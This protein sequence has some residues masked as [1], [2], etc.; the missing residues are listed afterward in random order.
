M[1]PSSGLSTLVGPPAA[2]RGLY[3]G[4]KMSDIS[5]TSSAQ[6]WRKSVYVIR[7]LRS[8]KEGVFDDRDGA[9][10]GVLLSHLLC[11]PA[12]TL[13]LYQPAQSACC[14]HY[15][16]SCQCNGYTT[17]K[18]RTTLKSEYGEHVERFCSWRCF[19]LPQFSEFDS[20]CQ[21][22]GWF[23]SMMQRLIITSSFLVRCLIVSKVAWTLAGESR[24]V[25]E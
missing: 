11:S 7:L 8:R 15:Q 5:R 14:H 24:N 20:C 13:S 23:F 6:H 1:H 4:R 17:G 18:W 25:E 2:L 21:F 16:H 10:R 12:G 22:V 19:P 3:R 9:E